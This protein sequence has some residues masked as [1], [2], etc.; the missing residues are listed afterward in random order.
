MTTLTV[1]LP[2]RLKAKVEASAKRRRVPKSQVV[3]EAL[4]RALANESKRS[5]VRAIDLVR[6]LVGCVR[7]GPRDLTTNPKYMED[8]GA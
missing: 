7:G 5:T 2:E 3:R 4:E 8:F 1:K 6:D